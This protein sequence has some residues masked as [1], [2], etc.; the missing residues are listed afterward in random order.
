[1]RLLL[2]RAGIFPVGHK[3][4]FHAVGVEGKFFLS[5]LSRLRAQCHGLVIAHTCTKQYAYTQWNSIPSLLPSSLTLAIILIP[6]LLVARS[7]P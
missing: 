4:F 6:R 3:K 2:V 5:K 7:S 1:M